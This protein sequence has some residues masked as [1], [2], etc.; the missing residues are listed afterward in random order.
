MV[1]NAF[2]C[3]TVPIVVKAGNVEICIAYQSHM[4]SEL[5]GKME[6][7]AKQLTVKIVI[8]DYLAVS[9]RIRSSPDKYGITELNDPCLSKVT[10][11]GRVVC[12]SP[13][14]YFFWTDLQITR[15][16]NQIMGEAMAEQLSK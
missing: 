16:I 5:P 10:A 15:R 13:D 1:V 4:I 14:E 12:E 11:E 8:F 2:D 3:S 7:L 9:D 6:N